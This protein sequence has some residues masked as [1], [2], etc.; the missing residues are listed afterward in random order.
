MARTFNIADGLRPPIER[1]LRRALGR[2]ATGITVVTTRGPEGMT[3]NA[4]SA[5]SLA[6]PLVL[7]CVRRNA[8]SRASFERGRYFAVNVLASDQRSLSVRFA[9]PAKDKFAGVK[10][11]KGLGGLPLIAGALACFECQQ[12]CRYDGGDHLIFVGQV[13]R[14]SYRDGEPLLFSAGRYAE[15]QPHPEDLGEPVETS[16]F[17]DLLL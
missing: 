4:F 10:C 11:H 17:A 16:E 15:V 2:F 6:P 3:A 13:K 8:P 14:F 9:T 1:E 12:Y 5:L 7:W